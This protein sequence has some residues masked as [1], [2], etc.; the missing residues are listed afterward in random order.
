VMDKVQQTFRIDP[1]KPIY[2]LA[3]K[4]QYNLQMYP[5]ALGVLR[6]LLL[7]FKEQQILLSQNKQILLNLSGECKNQEEVSPYIYFMP[8]VMEPAALQNHA[9]NLSRWMDCEELLPFCRLLIYPDAEVFNFGI[10]GDS[11]LLGGQT[12]Y[13]LEE[14]IFKLVSAEFIEE[15][16]INPSQFVQEH[17]ANIKPLTYYLERASSE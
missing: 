6:E 3:N 1:T 10:A 12:I 2:I 15:Y 5:T 4:F 11:Q 9:K 16:E 7:R 8:P 14:G 17:K 13:F